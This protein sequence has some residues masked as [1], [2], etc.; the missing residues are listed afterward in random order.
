MDLGE[1]MY[2]TRRAE[3]QANKTEILEGT[4]IYLF[5]NFDYV[6]ELGTFGHNQF[7]AEQ[8]ICAIVTIGEIIFK[9]EG[10]N[11]DINIFAKKYG[12]GELWTFSRF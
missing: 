5:Y 1:K 10:S 9:W 6:L 4:V 3:W 8:Q 7:P 2:G 11:N 12:V